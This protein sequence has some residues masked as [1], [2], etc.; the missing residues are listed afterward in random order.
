MNLR[1]QYALADA[2]WTIFTTSPV[3][4][5]SMRA[6]S[7]SGAEDIKSGAGQYFTPRPI[8]S[9][10]V[11]CVQPTVHDSVA[12]PA[13]GTAG[14]LLGAHEFA[15]QDSANM[16][17][18]ERAHLRDDFAHG[19]ELVDGTARLAAMNLLLH[20]IGQADNPP[21]GRKSSLTM[22]G[23]DGSDAVHSQP[24]RRRSTIQHRNWGYQRYCRG[25]L[26]VRCCRTDICAQ[27]EAQL[28]RME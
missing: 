18:P 24:G 5:A 15:A 8:I 7:P 17:S 27:R 12:D 20:G 26:D 4:G 10:M 13:C 22:V 2:D 25:A 14:F 6:S 11:D 16:T 9:A 23:A 3:C 21:F 28:D 19:V 1:A